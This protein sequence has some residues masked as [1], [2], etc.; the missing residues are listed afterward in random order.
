[1]MDD[2]TR[3]AI[4]NLISAI[5]I[6]D[7]RMRSLHPDARFD[8]KLGERLAKVMEALEARE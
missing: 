7:A 4:L 2:D 3:R 6:L 8:Y 5:H 1:M